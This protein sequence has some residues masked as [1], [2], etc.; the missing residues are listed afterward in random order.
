MTE[1]NCLDPSQIGIDQHRSIPNIDRRRIMT[2]P[3]YSKAPAADAMRRA[4]EARDRIKAKLPG[5]DGAAARFRQQHGNLGDFIL[6]EMNLGNDYRSVLTGFGPNFALAIVTMAMNSPVKQPDKL[7]ILF[8]ERLADDVRSHL[9]RL[10]NSGMSHQEGFVD[11]GDD[12]T[13]TDSDFRDELPKTPK[14]D[15]T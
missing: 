14:G 4:S 6:S 12:G 15:D 10:R 5:P 11:I 3:D 1:L 7:C 8:L 9:D 2:H 13:L